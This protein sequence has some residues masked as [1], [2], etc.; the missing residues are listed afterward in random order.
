MILLNTAIEF[1]T[2]IIFISNLNDNNER[3]HTIIHNE[4]IFSIELIFSKS[5][6]SLI[7]GTHLE[8]FIFKHHNQP[9][10]NF[11]HAKITAFSKYRVTYLPTYLPT[12]PTWFHHSPLGLFR[13]NETN[14]WNK[15][16]RLRIPTGRR[17]TS[18]LCTSTAKELNQGVPGTSPASGQSGTRT[19]DLQISN[20]MP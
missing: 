15:L 1:T 6:H 5:P 20:P 8:S 10:K 11:S 17:Q 14:N 19:R 18:W 3:Q 16:N 4:I 9:C 7:S 12:L 2:S 13:A